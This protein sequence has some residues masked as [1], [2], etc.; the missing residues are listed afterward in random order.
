[1]RLVGYLKKK[2]ITMQHGNMNVEFVVGCIVQQ[3]MAAKYSLKREELLTFF[4]TLEFVSG[5]IS[6]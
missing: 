5:I 4:Q 6:L 1:V 2:S 3:T